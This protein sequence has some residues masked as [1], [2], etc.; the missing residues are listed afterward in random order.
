M[1]K[2]IKTKL[3]MNNT[4]SNL[5]GSTN[6]RRMF[7]QH[8]AVLG[9]SSTLLPCCANTIAIEENN[10]ITI[11]TL[12]AAEKLADIKLSNGERKEILEKVKSNVETFKKFREQQLGYYS[13]PS[14]VFN[15][16]PPGFIY[17]HEQK[18][19]VFS[20]VK[21]Q[22]PQKIEDLAFYCIL[23]LANL[24]KT[25]Q[26]TSL[27]LTKLYL[28]R[29]KRYNNKLKFVVT[30]TDDLAIKQAKKA[31]KEIQTGNYKGLLHG[32]PYGIKDLFSVKGYKTTWG[33]RVFEERIIDIDATVVQKLEAA[34]AV[35]VAKL[36]TGTLASGEKWFGG[37]TKSPWTLKSSG[38][39]SAGP[40]SAVAAGCV[41]F[42]IG[43]E[44]N[45]SMVSPVDVCGVTGLRPTFGRVSRYG[46]MPVS[47]SFDKVTPIART[48]EDCAIVFNEIQGTDSF[49]NSV[50]DLPFNWNSQFDV[51]KLKIGY[52]S[53]YFEKEKKGIAQDK[54][55]ERWFNSRSAYI[56]NVFDL[57]KKK[58]FDLVPLDFQLPHKGEGIMMLVEAATAF[59]EFTRGKMDDEVE[60]QKWP[61]YHRVHRFVPAVEYLQAARYRSLM[62][63]KMNE[64]MKDV[65][66]YIEM[67]WSTNWS[68]NVTGLPIVV[69]PCGFHLNGQPTSVTF[70]GKPYQEEKVLAVA[71]M[72]QDSTD[73]H[74]RQ[75]ERLNDL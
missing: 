14:M 63:Q 56:K 41:A 60:D 59:D 11:E 40:A 30:F 33:A 43:T 35:L 47:W 3:M 37:R 1:K 29:L 51:K 16:V 58:G 39:S 31:D 4:N 53:T 24:L 68:T 48:V 19:I 25:Q 8:L 49:D 71:K 42:A 28:S 74:L 50:I 38:G 6:N 2:S 70:V 45:G 65:D 18:P 73:Y 12:E 61:N 15:P 57:I 75:P 17:D 20:E 62:I 5:K 72:F 46:C 21:T 26:V 23:Q 13:F 7:L 44:T 52:Y 9:I 54:D 27:E 34:G 67:T 64:I 10:G 69:V 32:I 66:V 55:Q 36:A 22:R